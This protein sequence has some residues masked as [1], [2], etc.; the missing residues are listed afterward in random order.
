MVGR[1]KRAGSDR[2]HA[3]ASGASDAVDTRGL[4]SLGEGHRRQNGGVPCASIMVKIR[5]YR[6]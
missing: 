4:K 3:V 2:R 5:L 6:D 1:A